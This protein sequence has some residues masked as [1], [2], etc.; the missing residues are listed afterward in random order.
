MSAQEAKFRVGQLVRHKLFDYRGV[1]FDVDPIF[2][3]TEEWYAQMARSQPPKDRP[4][5]HVLVHDAIHTTYVAEQNME[6]DFDLAP[7]RH[8]QVD[9]L[10]EGLGEDGY[11]PILRRN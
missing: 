6:P 3:G 8:P 4:W 2:L 11:I 10:F 1:V 7:I 5:Y 9:D